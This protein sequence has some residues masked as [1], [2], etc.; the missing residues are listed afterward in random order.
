MDGQGK[1]FGHLAILINNITTDSLE[2]GAEA[3]ELWILIEIGTM[4]Q[5]TGPGKDARY[6]IG[7]GFSSLKECL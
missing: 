1:I 4:T 2:D 3:S 5:S 6:R 7:T